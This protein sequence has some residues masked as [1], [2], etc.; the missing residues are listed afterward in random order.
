M[1]I[2]FH[3]LLNF[4][5]I[6]TFNAAISAGQ[7]SITDPPYADTTGFHL[8]ADLDM[9]LALSA[10][11]PEAANRNLQILQAFASA[12]DAVFYRNGLQILEVQGQRLHLFLETDDTGEESTNGLIGDCRIF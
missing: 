9:V 8:Y 3:Q 11:D 12:A 2:P 10:G 6:A 4:S 7:F 5:K 1:K